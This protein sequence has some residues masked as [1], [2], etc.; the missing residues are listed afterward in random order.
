LAGH[1]FH[2]LASIS[3]LRNICRADEMA[4]RGF[5]YVSVGRGGK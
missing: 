3:D 2:F 4:R 1:E 5:A